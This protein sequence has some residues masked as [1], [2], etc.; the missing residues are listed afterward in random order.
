[1]EEIARFMAKHLPPSHSKLYVWDTSLI[2]GQVIQQWRADLQWVTTQP[3]HA[4]DAVLFLNPS[5]PLAVEFIASLANA[6]RRGGR[7][8]GVVQGEP[9]NRAMVST[10][11]SVGLT[12]ILVEHLDDEK[13]AL[14]VLLRGE[15]AWHTASTFKRIHDVA[16]A[17]ADRLT[18]STYDGGYLYFP[19]IQKPNKPFWKLSADEK[20]TWEGM[21]WEGV[22]ACRLGFTSLPKAVGFMQWVVMRGL[23]KDVNKIG[24]YQRSVV[25][26]WKT[27]VVINPLPEDCLTQTLILLPLNPDEAEQS[28]E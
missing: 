17:D 7:I 6:L 5:V 16:Q 22:P 12:R 25:A 4:V 15:K 27:S 21:A 3:D 24:K 1:M 18:L 19:L 8:I 10:L 23:V 9:L 28:D 14:G 13:P 20:L 26:N 2:L 11:E